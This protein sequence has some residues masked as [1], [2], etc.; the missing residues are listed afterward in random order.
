MGALTLFLSMVLVVSA[1][2]KLASPQRMADAAARLAG[3]STAMGPPLAF[4]AAGVEAV[5]ALALLLSPT[6]TGGAMAACTL[7]C[8]YGALLFARRGQRLDCG[9]DLSVRAKPIGAFAIARPLFLAALALL[10]AFPPAA[11][12]WSIDAPFAALA[13]L[14]L[15]FAAAELGA[16]PLQARTR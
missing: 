2:H 16:L 7:W 14:A 4:A 11:L 12:A 15:W 5:A 10:V 9:C 1:G 8:G 6:H 13:L 3:L